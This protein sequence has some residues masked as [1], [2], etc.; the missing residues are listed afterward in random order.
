MLTKTKSTEEQMDYDQQWESNEIGSVST[1]V[2]TIFPSVVEI[3]AR[4]WYLL[5]LSLS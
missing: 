5:I 2:P 3:K 1:Q 4:I